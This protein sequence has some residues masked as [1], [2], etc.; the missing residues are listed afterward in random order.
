MST[1]QPKACTPMPE[2]WPPR[3]GEAMGGGG[4]VGKG[5]KPVTGPAVPTGT[6]RW[7]HF[8]SS[9][10]SGRLSRDPQCS[11]ASGGKGRGPASL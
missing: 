9:P 7:Q 8:T 5:T 11:S 10:A 1:R 3:V 4:Q 2:R 6:Q